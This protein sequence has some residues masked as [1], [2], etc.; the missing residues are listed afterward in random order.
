MIIEEGQLG[1]VLDCP[2]LHSNPVKSVPPVLLIVSQITVGTVGSRGGFEPGSLIYTAPAM[3]RDKPFALVK[4]MP[5][6][7]VPTDE[8]NLA[9]TPCLLRS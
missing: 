2:W 5:Y 4:R 1:E 8:G 3:V 9:P 6:S 7:R